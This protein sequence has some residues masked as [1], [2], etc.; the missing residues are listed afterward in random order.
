MDK[1]ISYLAVA[2]VIGATVVGV[3]LRHSH[4]GSVQHTVVTECTGTEYVAGD[5]VYRL[6]PAGIEMRS[7]S[8]H[9]ELTVSLQLPPVRAG[10]NQSTL[11]PA[12]NGDLFA[13]SLVEAKQ[14]VPVTQPAA[15]IQ[16]GRTPGTVLAPTFPHP[17]APKAPPKSAFDDV[18]RMKWA[19]SFKGSTADLTPGS[20]LKVKKLTALPVSGTGK[21]PKY[22][23][24]HVSTAQLLV[25]QQQQVQTPVAIV[26]GSTL[27]T[28]QDV[29]DIIA[30]TNNG[31][32]YWNCVIGRSSLTLQQLASPGSAPILIRKGISDFVPIYAVEGGFA[33]IENQ[34][35]PDKASLL[36]IARSSDGATFNC[37]PNNASARTGM[38]A[39]AGNWAAWG[40]G[41]TT[42]TEGLRVA[43][44]NSEITLCRLVPSAVAGE[45][46]TGKQYHI[47]AEGLK[48]PDGEELQLRDWGPA[49]HNGKLYCLAQTVSQNRPWY[50]QHLYLCRVSLPDDGKPAIQQSIRLPDGADNVQSNDRG[51][52][53]QLYP[54]GDERGGE[55]KNILARLDWPRD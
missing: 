15:S 41:S 22:S 37:G 52:W 30:Q 5:S 54:R 14:A 3:K 10:E 31:K 24:V 1:R 4:L 9:K 25:T 26:S 21:T 53:F 38:A 6:L 20:G 51:I 40:A 2:I 18:S 28:M 36:Y 19:G 35:Y 17:N 48:T 32:Q 55:I 45:P 46:G 42:I 12:A 43:K 34:P 8:L 50:D 11:I 29:P 44:V 7:L 33:W 23:I 16:Q 13:A 47:A 49:W 27:I 39:I